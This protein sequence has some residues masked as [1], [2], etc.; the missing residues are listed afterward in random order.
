MLVT[1]RKFPEHGAGTDELPEVAPIERQTR[2]FVAAEL[3]T[4]E[5]VVELRSA[6]STPPDGFPF[7]NGPHGAFVY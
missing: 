3:A 4:G 7:G 1:A 2:P 5:P 6:P